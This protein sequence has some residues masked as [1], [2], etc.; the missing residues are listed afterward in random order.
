M[1]H[2][3]FE[4]LG[5]SLTGFPE[6]PKR[7]TEVHTPLGVYDLSCDRSSEA[8]LLSYLTASLKNPVRE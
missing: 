1:V 3:P 6:E 8:A 5:N 4:I 2:G 7:G